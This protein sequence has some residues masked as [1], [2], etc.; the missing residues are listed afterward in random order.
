LVSVDLARVDAIELEA[1]LRQAWR[2]TAPR[3][4]ASGVAVA[5]G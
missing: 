5:N 4:L 3:K 1:L 2:M